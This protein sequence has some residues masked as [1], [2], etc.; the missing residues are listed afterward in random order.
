MNFFS[1]QDKAR[2]HTAILILLFVLAVACLVG[3]TILFVAIAFSF[4]NAYA[5]ADGSFSLERID[6]KL[7]WQVAAAVVLVVA[8][9]SLIKM[10]ALS[11]GGA[12]V[13]ELLGG[14]LVPMDSKDPAHR[15]VLNVVEEMSIAS[16]IPVP[17]VY[18]LEESG[19]NAFAAGTRIDNAVIGITRG[20]LES[21]TR[22]ELQGVVGHEFSHILNG[23]MRLNIH[24]TGLLHGILIIALTGRYLM[25]SASH[26]HRHLHRGR[27]SGGAL[28]FGLGLFL[29]GS[30]G[31]FFGNV[32][33]AMV[34]RQREYLADASAVQFTRNNAGIANALKRIGGAE[35][36]SVLMTPSAE[37]YSHAYFAEGISHF[38]GGL[39]ATHPPLEER[40]LRLDPSWD[41]RYLKPLQRVDLAAETEEQRRTAAQEKHARQAAAV[42]GGV[43]VAQA[44]E[45]VDAIGNPQ[46]GH[47]ERAREQVASL[48]ERLLDEARNPWG[49]RAVVYALL[50]H[51][52]EKIRVRQ[53]RIL[54]ARALPE[55]LQTTREITGLVATLDDEQVLS[56]LELVPGALRQQ[57]KSQFEEWRGNVQALIDTDGKVDFHEW[58]TVR[59]VLHPLELQHGLRRHLAARFNSLDTV[60]R[61]VAILL[62]FAA[63]LEHADAAGMATAFREGA[64]RAGLSNINLQPEAELT[65]PALD[66]AIS[67]LDQLKPLVKPR[68]L[69]AL[70]GTLAWDGKVSGAGIAF[71]RAISA[72]I[73]C[74]MPPLLADID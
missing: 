23:D 38:L 8:G 4:N 6:P 10:V 22:D 1:A 17:P 56:L 2:K 58:V 45:A 55:V 59:L 14:R 25:R 18:L 49:A 20:A 5:V 57:S 68:L 69:K 70:V 44:L 54:E 28:L 73:D 34:S 74:P 47:V 7:A 9:G 48:P 62:S 30:I 39:L 41:G 61:E 65:L 37:E 64:N 43:T 51:K 35:S 52:D 42:M 60:A 13:A 12:N 72:S 71:L 27:G 66:A 36:G 50:L 19:I 26:S 21:L 11:G 46:A 31:H 40:I 53:W 3:L 32:I 24:L 15:K 29:I 67:R 63:G 33:K 16:G